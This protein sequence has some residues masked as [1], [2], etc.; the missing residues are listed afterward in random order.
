MLGIT[1]LTYTSLISFLIV[2]ILG[3]I[4]IPML[5]KFK[6]G[7]TV[8]DDGPKTHLAKN[9]TPTMGGILMIVAI[10]ITGLTRSKVGPDMVIGLICI[11]GF[12]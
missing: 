3:P 8:R 1:E 11:F 5:T 7:Q 2:V 4:F 6:F 9:G 12:G 10:L